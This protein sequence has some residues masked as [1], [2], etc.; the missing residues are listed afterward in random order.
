MKTK[1]AL[2][3][4][5]IILGISCSTS[6]TVTP[7]NLDPEKGATPVTY[8]EK[9]TALCNCYK[10]ANG[11]RKLVKVCDEYKAKMEKGLNSNEAMAFRIAA[12]LCKDRKGDFKIK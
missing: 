12:Q 3:I 7:I 6:K 5:S 1:L 2:I 9:A 4:I 10:E 11:S 8:K